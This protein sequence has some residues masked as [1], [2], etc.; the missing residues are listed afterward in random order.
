MKGHKKS[1]LF[2]QFGKGLCE[3]GISGNINENTLKPLAPVDVDA[4][5]V[6]KV[7]ASNVAQPVRIAEVDLVRGGVSTPGVGQ[8]RLAHLVRKINANL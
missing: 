6:G 7:E 2:I 3:P 5:V 1:S 4:Q 8:L